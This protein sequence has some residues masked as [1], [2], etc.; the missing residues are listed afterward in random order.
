MIQSNCSKSAIPAQ[1]W[2]S[3]PCTLT[4]SQKGIYELEKDGGGEAVVRICLDDISR[5]LLRP[6]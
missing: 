3:P 5:E 1:K 4:V 2:R 6:A